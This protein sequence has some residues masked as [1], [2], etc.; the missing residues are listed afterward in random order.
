MYGGASHIADGAVEGW[1][2]R[3]AFCP[4]EAIHGALSIARYCYA[5]GHLCAGVV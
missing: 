2:G 1:L 4:E 3:G 5:G